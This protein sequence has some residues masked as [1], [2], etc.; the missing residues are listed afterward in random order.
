[1]ITGL[2]RSLTDLG[3]R[4]LMAALPP[5]MRSWGWAVRSEAARIP[6]DG[7]ALSFVI[8]SL[9]GLL[10]RAIVARLRY[11]TETLFPEGSAPMSIVTMPVR[12]RVLGIVCATGAVLLG[13]AY[14]AGAGAPPRYLALNGGALAIGLVLLW[15]IARTVPARPHLAGGMMIAMATLLL[16]TALLGARV[17]GAARWVAVGGLSI[18]PSLILLPTM[19]VLFAR[20]RGRIAAAAIVLAA[21]AMALQPDRAMAGMMVASLGVVA[22]AHRERSVVI[23][24]CAAVAAFAATLIRA[25]GLPAVPYVDRILYSSFE[26][27]PG[28]GLAVAG[29]SALLLLPPI[30]GWLANRGDRTGHAAFG[31]VWSAAILAAA[32]GNYPTPVV[33]YGGSAIIGYFLSLLA[34]PA[35]ATAPVRAAGQTGNAADD[36]T[37]DRSL[38]ARAA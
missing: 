1:M 8:G 5:A 20:D 21:A 24:L 35:Y 3:A 4:L 7:E 22:V 36:V 9:C 33:G 16:A 30:V 10:P 38:L 12:P 25:D 29:G 6:D 27:H 13:L 15:A 19:L 28:A 34:L 14:L 23:A 17:D 37:R 18:Q 32:L 11:R 26:V 31:A 2:R